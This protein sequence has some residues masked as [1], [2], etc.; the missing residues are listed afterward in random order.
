[1]YQLPQTAIELPCTTDYTSC[2]VQHSLQLVGDDLWSPVEDN[3]TVVNARRHEGV[4]E[5][6]GIGL[7][8]TVSVQLLCS[9]LAEVSRCK[10]KDI[11]A[12]C[13]LQ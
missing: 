11:A 10:L 7:S 2:G 12:S 4:H 5:R 8:R 3:V 6:R 13:Q 1:M 9:L